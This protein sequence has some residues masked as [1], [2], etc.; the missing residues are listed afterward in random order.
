[1]IMI[2]ALYNH[3]ANYMIII[4]SVLHNVRRLSDARQTIQRISCSAERVPDGLRDGGSRGNLRCRVSAE[5]EHGSVHDGLTP[6]GVHHVE[7][8][9]V[10]GLLG[11]GH[12][13]S[14]RQTGES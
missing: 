1:M 11:D 8:T 14:C 2:M 5:V 9:L 6:A 13:R 4:M 12:P 10:V 3:A 7:L